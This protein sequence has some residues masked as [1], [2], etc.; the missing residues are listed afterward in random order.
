[1]HFL[2][3]FLYK[4]TQNQYAIPASFDLWIQNN[5]I[6]WIIEHFES[7]VWIEFEVA[8]DFP[9]I[10]MDL[11]TGD[12]SYIVAERTKNLLHLKTAEAS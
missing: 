6:I 4:W 2:W 7:I 8:Y 5:R 3:I 10:K 12:S 11:Q 1:M 9:S